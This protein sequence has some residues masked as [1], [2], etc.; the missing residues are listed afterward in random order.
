M[1]LEPV[2]LFGVVVLTKSVY[3]GCGYI[4]RKP[5]LL[6]QWVEETPG[7]SPIVHLVECASSSYLLRMILRSPT[8]KRHP[9]R[10]FLFAPGRRA[11][12]F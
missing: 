11:S 1:T 3:A 6:I 9:P 12:I 10:S 4:E 7:S 5:K 8:D 2:L